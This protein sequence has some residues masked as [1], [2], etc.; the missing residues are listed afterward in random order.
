MIIKNNLYSMQF[1]QCEFHKC[2]KI[3]KLMNMDIFPVLKIAE[4]G[5]WS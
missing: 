4:K 3:M 5:L 1:I 2:F